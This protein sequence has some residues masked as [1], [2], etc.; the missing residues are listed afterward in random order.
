MAT[1]YCGDVKITIKYTDRSY[2]NRAQYCGKV[3]HAGYV[4]KFS[5]LGSGCGGVSSGKGYAYPDDS[6]EAYDEMARSALSF[7]QYT[8]DGEEN[9]TDEPWSNEEQSEAFTSAAWEY[10]EQDDGDGP[11]IYRTH[12]SKRRKA[13]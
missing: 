1:R 6:A 4:W 13:A 9:E 3:E 12:Y 8:G 7:A 5:G 2:D 10:P 11:T